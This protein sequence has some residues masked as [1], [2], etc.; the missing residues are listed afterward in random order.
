PK[1]EVCAGELAGMKR[2]AKKCYYHEHPE[3]FMVHRMINPK[4]GEAK[5]DFTSSANWKVGELYHFMNWLQMVAGGDGLVL[6]SKG[7]FARN[8]RRSS[9]L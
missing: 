7:E 3:A 2:H 5:P 4:T 8:K 9:G 6:E 1:R